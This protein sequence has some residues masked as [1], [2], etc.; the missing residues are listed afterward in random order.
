LELLNCEALLVNFNESDFESLKLPEMN[1][2]Y[3]EK[4]HHPVCRTV[5]LWI[6]TEL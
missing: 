4:A 5:G 1:E 2:N 6:I 3:I